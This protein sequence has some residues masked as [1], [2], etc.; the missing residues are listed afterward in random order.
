MNPASQEPS[1]FMKNSMILLLVFALS[2]M[3]TNID[4]ECFYLRGTG[5]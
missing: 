3:S 5:L 1:S 2:V 4:P